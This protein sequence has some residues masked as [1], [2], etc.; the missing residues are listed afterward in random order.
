MGSIIFSVIFLCI[1]IR[2]VVSILNENI[3]NKRKSNKKDSQ[4]NG[5]F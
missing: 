5:L 2:F 3:D 4:N 1:S